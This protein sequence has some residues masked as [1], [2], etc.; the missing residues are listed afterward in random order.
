[1][2]LATVRALLAA[3]APLIEERGLTLVGLAVANLDDDS[4]VQLTLPFDRGG[5]GALDAALDDVRVRFGTKAI[6]RAVLLH[7]GD[8]M[9][10]PLLP[11]PPPVRV[12]TAP[13]RTAASRL[14]TSAGS[15]RSRT[16]TAS[17]NVLA[18]MPGCSTA[19]ATP[20]VGGVDAGD[21]SLALAA[22]QRAQ[23]HGDRPRLAT[24]RDEA[25]ADQRLVAAA[26][27]PVGEV[28]P[29]RHRAERRLAAIDELA[30]DVVDGVEVD[31]H[32]LDRAASAELGRRDAEVEVDVR[33]HPEQEVLEDDRPPA[34]RRPGTPPAT[35]RRTAPRHA[36]PAPRRGSGRRSR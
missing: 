18:G 26:T 14:M 11:D 7:R 23:P 3:A 1:M 30:E 10:M 35:T 27:D 34:A 36:R 15:A 29:R 2:V 32:G 33:V 9:E 21:R 8:D 17:S 19:R 25:E 4:A 24:G 20:T 5:A 13:G 31:P 22:R 12:I 28:Q 6:T 16:R